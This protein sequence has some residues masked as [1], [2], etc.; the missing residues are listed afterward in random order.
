MTADHLL[1]PEFFGQSDQDA[2]GA[3]EV[4][5]LVDVFVVYH[6]AE[7]FRAV[8]FQAGHDVVDAGDGE[9]EAADA[10]GVHGR[11]RVGGEGF[12]CV[13]FAEFKAAVAIGGAQHDDVAADAAE[14]DEAVD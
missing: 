14:V 5:E 2:F 6:F 11:V 10:L 1:F 12:W 9:H 8:F 13:K 7:Q 4:A 3:A